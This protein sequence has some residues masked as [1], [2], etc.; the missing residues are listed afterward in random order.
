VKAFLSSSRAALLNRRRWRQLHRSNSK[1][2]R[3]SSRTI[4]PHSPAHKAGLFF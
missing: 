2:R 1:P 4:Y 3:S